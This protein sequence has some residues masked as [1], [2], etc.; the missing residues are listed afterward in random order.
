MRALRTPMMIMVLM[1][2]WLESSQLKDA[3]AP[4]VLPMASLSYMQVRLTRLQLPSDKQEEYTT[5]D[6][7]IGFRFPVAHVNEYN[8][9]PR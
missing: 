1:F 6:P 8:L 3:P 2:I 9:S 5:V 4:A 7:L